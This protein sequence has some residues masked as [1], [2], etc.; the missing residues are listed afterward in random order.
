MYTQVNIVKILGTNTIGRANV[1]RVILTKLEVIGGS[2]G[3]IIDMCLVMALP[4]ERTIFEVKVPVKNEKTRATESTGLTN[5][6]PVEANRDP[7]RWSAE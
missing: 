1:E 6:H 5:Q 4:L 2:E 7:G 3:N